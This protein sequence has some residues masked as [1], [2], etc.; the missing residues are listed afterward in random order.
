MPSGVLLDRFRISI[1]R[2][3]Q[4]L[5]IE[6]QSAVLAQMN[7]D[8][9]E[10]LWKLLQSYEENFQMDYVM[11]ALLDARVGTAVGTPNGHLDPLS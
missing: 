7:K 6:I 9:E 2:S 1:N 3:I 10:D 4:K 11:P 5:P 8:L